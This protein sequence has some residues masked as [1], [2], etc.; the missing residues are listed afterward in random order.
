[1]PCSAPPP[2]VSRIGRGAGTR[3]TDSPLETHPQL[4]TRLQSFASVGYLIGLPGSKWA[5]GC[6]VLDRPRQR[7]LAPPGAYRGGQVGQPERVEPTVS[8]VWRFGYLHVVI[9]SCW[10]ASGS[11]CLANPLGARGVLQALGRPLPLIGLT[12]GSRL[13]TGIG[14]RSWPP[15]ATGTLSP[16]I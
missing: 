11:V 14:R 10:P 15:I 5:F 12:R 3:P 6:P 13:S 9:V 1:M 8:G 16:G 4:L 2:V 7:P